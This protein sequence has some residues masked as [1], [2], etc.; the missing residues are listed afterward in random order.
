MAM[1]FSE[2]LCEKT[3]TLDLTLSFKELPASDLLCNV[4]NG[5]ARDYHAYLRCHLSCIAVLQ[6]P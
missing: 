5:L 2:Q 4:S 1:P 3:F 6:I